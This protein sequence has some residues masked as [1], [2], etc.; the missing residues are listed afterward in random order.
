MVVASVTSRLQ[1]W[2]LG[3]FGNPRRGSCSVLSR[4]LGQ[5]FQEDDGKATKGCLSVIAHRRACRTAHVTQKVPFVPQGGLMDLE[6]HLSES[7][8]KARIVS[9]AGGLTTDPTDVASSETLQMSGH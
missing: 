3:G 2:V 1:I 7:L 9:S 6:L 5:L 8:S 4:N